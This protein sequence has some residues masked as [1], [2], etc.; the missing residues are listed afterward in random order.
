MATGKDFKNEGKIIELGGK[1]RH[2]LFDMN[3][4]CEL[5][6]IYE[7]LDIAFKELDKGKMK[8]IRAILFSCMAYEDEDLTLLKVGQMINDTNIGQIADDLLEL[9]GGALPEV[10]E[11]EKNE[12]EEELKNE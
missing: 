9:V 7:D 4:Y 6:S 5:E 3:A 2:L 10:E 12:D 8:A 11:N 1:K